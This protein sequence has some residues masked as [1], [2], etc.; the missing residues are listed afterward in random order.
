MEVLLL[1]WHI[2][3]TLPFMG[4]QAERELQRQAVI[5]IREDGDAWEVFAPKVRKVQQ[6]SRGRTRTV[7]HP[8]LSGY[9][10]LRFDKELHKW[11][12]VNNTYGVRS[13]MGNN[14]HNPAVVRDNVMRGLMDKCTVE[15]DDAGRLHHYVDE[16]IADR[17][18]FTVGDVVTVTQGPFT[19]LEGKVE[20]STYERVSVLLNGRYTTSLN[21]KHLELV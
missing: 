5:Q 6:W 16:V 18:M 9:L 8:Y 3:E 12:Q 14:K 19:G 20:L 17:F 21:S 4:L 11:Q 13:L 10:F 2:A 7:Y 15:M 1:A